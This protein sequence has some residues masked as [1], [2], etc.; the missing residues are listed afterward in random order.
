[1]HFCEIMTVDGM[2]F[3]IENFIIAFRDIPSLVNR[4]GP[5]NVLYIIWISPARFPANQE[6]AEQALTP[7]L[8]SQLAPD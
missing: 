7:V 1:M 4:Q 5:K 8:I 6:Q 3:C 2:P